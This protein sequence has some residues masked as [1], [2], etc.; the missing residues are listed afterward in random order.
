MEIELN[1]N[2][3][4]RESSSTKVYYLYQRST[5]YCEFTY[6]LMIQFEFKITWDP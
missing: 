4:T 6:T 3:I 5:S 1:I 2:L